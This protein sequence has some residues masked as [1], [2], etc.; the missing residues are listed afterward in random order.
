MLFS[1]NFKV[2]FHVRKLLRFGFRQFE[3]NFALLIK[4]THNQEREQAGSQ[5]VNHQSI[6]QSVS[7]FVSQSM[8]QSIK[9]K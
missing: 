8:S 6:K 1:G 7:P 9:R 4:N 2:S 5:S 3:S